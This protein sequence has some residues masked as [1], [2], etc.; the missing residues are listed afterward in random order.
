MSYFFILTLQLH[1]LPTDYA[2]EL[3][4]CLN[5]AANLLD[6][7][8]KIWKVLDFEFFV[9]D[10]ISGVGFKPFWLRLPGLGCQPPGGI[11]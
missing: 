6:C 9:G 2:K 3:F 4:K 8:E 1:N 10:I 11:F 5:D 7:I